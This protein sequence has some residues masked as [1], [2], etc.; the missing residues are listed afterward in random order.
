MSDIISVYT[1]YDSSDADLIRA[2]LESEGISC[3]LK[4]DNAGG[5]LPYL[6]STHGIEIMINAQDKDE[7]L[8]I[9][10]SRLAQ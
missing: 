1:T 8:A 9:L 6:T 5:A 3:F 2:Q 7:V 4:S 10:R